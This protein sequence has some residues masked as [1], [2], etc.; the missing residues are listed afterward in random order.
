MTTAT[1][2]SLIIPVGPEEQRVPRVIKD[3]E[4]L[5]ASWEII[6]S[7]TS[8]SNLTLPERCRRIEGLPGRGAQLN[9]GIEAAQGRWLWLVHAD[10]R[11]D[12]LAIGSIRDL[13]DRNRPCLGYCDLEFEDDGPR[14]AGLNAVGANWR[15]RWLNLPYGD[16]G[17]CLRRADI[18]RLGGFR[19]DLARGEDLDLLIRARRLGLAV[20]RLPGRMT[21]S[22]RRYR[23][24]GW[25]KTTLV[26]Q[27][28]AVR[29]IRDARRSRITP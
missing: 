10:S 7:L 18:I 23:T 2:L 13:A 11:P 14:L 24:H 27:F 12:D 5:P 21:T 15:S 20:Q 6:V 8:G 1:R 26:H 17:Y 3:P 25:L 16:Q 4:H 28:A 9:R 22:A 19:S 29:L